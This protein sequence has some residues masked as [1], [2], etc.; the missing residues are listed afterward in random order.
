MA[1]LSIHD[2]AVLNC[3]F[4]PN[5]PLTEAYAEELDSKITGKDIDIILR[6]NTNF[7]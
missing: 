1:Q 6:K 2:R 4:N 3:V 5:L 7:L